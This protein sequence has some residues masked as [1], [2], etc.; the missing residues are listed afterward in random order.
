MTPEKKTM[1][2]ALDRAL[3]SAFTRRWGNAA[4]AGYADA[5]DR[6]E[7]ANASPIF[8][9]IDAKAAGLLTHVS[10]MIAGLG[11]VA[12]LVADS[13]FEVGMIVAEIAVYLLIA[14]G[15]LRCL[16]VFGGRDVLQNSDHMEEALGRE[17]IIRRELYAVCN[18]AAIFF[19]IVVFLLLPFQFL[20]HPA[21]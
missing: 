7:K 14:V 9:T 6:Q 3:F 11:L 15:C 17:L 13:D 1:H 21:K 19:T 16:S 4:I 2:S 12:P 8:S 18:R 5:M 20:W 10:M